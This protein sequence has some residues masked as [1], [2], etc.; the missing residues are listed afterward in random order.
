MVGPR[1]FRTRSTGARKTRVAPG[2]G[3]RAADGP[4]S[5]NGAD[6]E[7]QFA[8]CLRWADHGRVRSCR[9]RAN[10]NLQDRR[11]R[12][13]TAIFI[14]GGR[15]YSS[16]RGRCVFRVPASAVRG[17]RR[18]C[19][20]EDRKGRG[21]SFETMSIAAQHIYLGLLAKFSKWPASSLTSRAEADKTGRELDYRSSTWRTIGKGVKVR[22]IVRGQPAEK[23]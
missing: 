8:V 22:R 10:R 20:R 6:R 12:I 19:P 7:E 16:A 13:E 21:F 3:A 5:K 11:R 9:R 1:T 2:R 18:L 23:W 4:E 17:G 15:K 14:H